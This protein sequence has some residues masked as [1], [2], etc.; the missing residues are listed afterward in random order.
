MLSVTDFKYRLK[1]NNN[2]SYESLILARPV[3]YSGLTRN[4]TNR[5]SRFSTHQKYQ[6][7]QSVNIPWESLGKVKIKILLL[8]TIVLGGLL[9]AQLVFATNLSTDGQTLTSVEKQ[10]ESQETENLNLRS[11]IA[12]VSSLTNLS[13]KAQNLGFETPEKI[14]T[15]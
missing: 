14:I 2:N 11:K 7:V 5:F 12:E 3:S 13:Q 10:I 8:L 6:H 1:P 4:K 15:P 9:S